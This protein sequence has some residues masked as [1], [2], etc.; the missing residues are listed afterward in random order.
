MG[1]LQINQG[2]FILAFG[3]E[4]G[5]DD[6]FIYM[7]SG[8]EPKTRNLK[9]GLLI[10]CSRSEIIGFMKQERGHQDSQLWRTL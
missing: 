5:K 10:L 6:V 2:L 3:E 9:A 7:N 1:G 4:I 8:Q